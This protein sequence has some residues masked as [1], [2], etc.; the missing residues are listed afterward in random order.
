MSGIG[1][2]EVRNTP[3]VKHKATTIILKRKTFIQQT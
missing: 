1:D 2:T 3:A